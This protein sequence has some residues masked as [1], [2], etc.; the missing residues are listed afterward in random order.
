V[1]RLWNKERH[2]DADIVRKQLRQWNTYSSLSNQGTQLMA[3]RKNTSRTY[4]PRTSLLE[5]PKM[6]QANRDWLIFRAHEIAIRT[7]ANQPLEQAELDAA[8]GW[9]RIVDK[10]AYVQCLNDVA[11]ARRA[12][13]LKFPRAR[14]LYLVL[15]DLNNGAPIPWPVHHVAILRRALCSLED[16]YGALQQLRVEQR[17]VRIR[18][19]L[20]ASAISIRWTFDQIRITGAEIDFMRGAVNVVSNGQEE[21]DDIEIEEEDEEVKV[22]VEEDE[23][24]DNEDEEPVRDGRRTR[25][26]G[27]RN[28]Q[29]QKNKADKADDGDSQD[30][31]DDRDIINGRKRLRKEKDKRGPRKKRSP[32]DE[33][34]ANTRFK[35]RWEDFFDGIDFRV[36]DEWIELSEKA[37]EQWESGGPPEHPIGKDDDALEEFNVRMNRPLASVVGEAWQ[38]HI[39]QHNANADATAPGIDWGPILQLAREGAMQ[40]ARDGKRTDIW[41]PGPSDDIMTGAEIA[42]TF[43][44]GGD[45]TVFKGQWLYLNSIGDG[46]Q[47]ELASNS[48]MKVKQLLTRGLQEKQDC[49]SVVGSTI[50]AM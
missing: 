17:R 7:A 49:G 28:G 38:S 33:D 8:T 27:G 1:H 40:R 11:E 5:I 24:E 20:N 6:A 25:T 42:N 44:F 12:S 30:P 32:S 2:P 47:G 14:D 35:K 26:P 31:D 43:G 4:G 3:T 21:P 39:D 48:D 13:D 19:P 45:P 10:S 34:I 36:L 15:G 37:H 46:A 41:P 29:A 23:D 22:K 9:S 50:M 18:D 16:L